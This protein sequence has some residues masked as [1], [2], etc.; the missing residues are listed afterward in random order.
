MWV[1]DCFVYTNS[2]WR[3]NYAVGSEVTTL[4]HLD[5]PMFLLGYLATQNRV[6]LID[7]EFNVVPYTL[8]LQLVEYKTLVLRDNFEAAQEILPTI[9]K[10]RVL[11]VRAVCVLH[12]GTVSTTVAHML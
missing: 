5:R 4:A 1:G 3:L 7:K 9:P 12:D 10:V 11:C 2:A 6:Y 8:L